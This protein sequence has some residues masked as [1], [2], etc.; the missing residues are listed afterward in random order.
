MDTANFEITFEDTEAIPALSQKF[1]CKTGAGSAIIP[2]MPMWP[3]GPSYLRID[4]FDTPL[5]GRQITRQPYPALS[6]GGYLIILVQLVGV[7]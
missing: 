5:A 2:K 1:E 4:S 3:V 7:K 6:S